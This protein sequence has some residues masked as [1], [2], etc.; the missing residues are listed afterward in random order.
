MKKTNWLHWSAV[1]FSL[2]LIMTGCNIG[3]RTEIIII[4]DN[5]EQPPM[6][7]MNKSFK[8]KS[9]YRLPPASKLLGWSD[10]KSVIGIF[11]EEGLSHLQR[12][13]SPYEKPE[14]LKKMNN[15]I[16]NLYMS[17][18]GK[19]IAQTSLSSNGP[20][21][22]LIS[23][24]DKKEKIVMP[25]KSN[26]NIYFQDIAWSNNNRYLCFL[27]N[28]AMIDEPTTVGVFDTVLNN[29]QTYELVEFKDEGTFVGVNISDDGKNLLFTMIPPSNPSNDKNLI[30]GTV[31]SNKI[32]IKYTHQTNGSKTTWLNNHQFVFLGKDETLYEYDCR[33]GDLSILLEKVSIYEFSND[34]KKI[35][36]SLND[37]DNVYIGRFQGK[38][39]LNVEIIY[40]GLTPYELYWSLDNQSLLLQGGKFPRN[41]QTE[42]QV[43]IIDF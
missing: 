28:S 42:E 12:L 10:N 41:L 13:L 30:M 3:K 35:A 20:S 31:N 1:L 40:Q 29:L 6:D 23:V 24:K 11:K 2:T 15:N 39:I 7:Q 33:N 8:V 38:N 17:P 9:I 18:D 37:Q 32:E 27:S 5:S 16:F 4:S 26:Q 19:I 14:V 22:K 36:Y 43:F 25:L 34:Q 21:L